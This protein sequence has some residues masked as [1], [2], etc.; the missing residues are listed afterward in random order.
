MPITTSAIGLNI[1]L[2]VG[3][4]ISQLPVSVKIVLTVVLVAKFFLFFFAVWF[5]EEEKIRKAGTTICII[6]N[7]AI[8]IYAGL[9]REFYI[10]V[11]AAILLA[12]LLVWSF[13]AIFDFE[14]KRK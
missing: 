2:G 1:I 3:V 14:I 8:A 6:L 9:M 10:L 11:S 12:A 4:W 13:A 7:C 5:A